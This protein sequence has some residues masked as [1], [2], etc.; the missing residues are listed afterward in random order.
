MKHQIER[1]VRF[2][3]IDIFACVR[4]QLLLTLSDAGTFFLLGPPPPVAR[5]VVVDGKEKT[6]IERERATYRWFQLAPPVGSLAYLRP[7]VAG[8]ELRDELP[9]CLPEAA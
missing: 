9:A 8:E 4:C 6:V 3:W 5:V 1:R 2:P 7:F